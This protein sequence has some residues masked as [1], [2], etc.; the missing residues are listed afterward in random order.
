[1]NALLNCM[2]HVQSKG[3]RVSKLIMNTTNQ[4]FIDVEPSS[5]LSNLE[6]HS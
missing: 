2:P 1:M 4:R 5:F 3:V 6:S